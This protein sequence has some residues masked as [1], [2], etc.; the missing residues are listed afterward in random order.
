MWLLGK[1]D[2]L[3]FS[4]FLKLL[5]FTSLAVIITYL[6]LLLLIYYYY[7]LFNRA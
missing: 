2:N 5:H 3:C 7:Y 1:K 4:F 6:L